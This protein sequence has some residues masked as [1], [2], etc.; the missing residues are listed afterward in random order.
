MH[1]WNFRPALMLAVHVNPWTLARLKYRATSDCYI[2]HSM[3]IQNITN[4]S[5]AL[6]EATHLPPTPPLKTSKTDATRL[7]ILR[8]Q[9][10][11]HSMVPGG[12]LVM[13]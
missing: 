6:D 10:Y 5:L 4:R 11:S 8:F 12:L 13:S 1:D 3:R 7:Q 2:L 9:L